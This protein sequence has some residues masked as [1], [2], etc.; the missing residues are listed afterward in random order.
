MNDRITVI[1]GAGATVDATH[2]STDFLTKKVINNC[3]KYT[4]SDNDTKS[5][6][7]EICSGLQ[8]MSKPDIVNFEVIYHIL[9]LLL[10]YHPDNKSEQLFSY[11]DIFANL[12]S[13]FK[14]IDIA[15][16][17][18]SINAIINTVN[19]EIADYDV[20]FDTSDYFNKFF[21]VLSKKKISLDVFNL[22]YDT[23]VEQSL[24]YYND[25]YVN[26]PSSQIVKRFDITEY[27]KQDDR[28][29]V[30]HL[31]GQ[32]HFEYPE[33]DIVQ[34]N[35]YFK[36][37]EVYTLYKYNNYVDAKKHRE[38]SIRTSDK[39]QYGNALFTSNIITGLMKNDK[40]LW[41]PFIAYHNKLV[42]SL[43]SNP[44]LIII[45]YG[46]SDLYLNRLLLQYHNN[47]FDNKKTLIIDYIDKNKYNL[48]YNSPFDSAAKTKF[49]NY[50]FKKDGWYHYPKYDKGDFFLSNDNAVCIYKN[51]FRDTVNHHL[52][53]ICNFFINDKVHKQDSCC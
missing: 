19:D 52:D 49:T 11:Y 50:I 18:S 45:G 5:I 34:N 30:S 13:V 33:F 9:E 6:V 27:L 12:N 43:L 1:L 26:I 40:L 7:D 8:K 41:N 35:E 23:W 21:S 47:F 46:F 20:K 22:N 44:N 51:G 48:A 31:H 37:E 32:I 15:N 4:I 24:Q 25:G 10:N 3:Q 2:V 42:N 38:Q 39:T 17:F 14:N 16:V 36:R 29:T 28:H 53:D